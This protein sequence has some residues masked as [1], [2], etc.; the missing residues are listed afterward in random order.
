MT[1]GMEEP[2]A[3]EREGPN[4]EAEEERDGKIK[5]EGK[6]AG[7]TGSKEGENEEGGGA[8]AEV[9]EGRRSQ[10]TGG[11]QRAPSN[12][13]PY[14]REY[15]LPH[16]TTHHSF[17]S[18]SFSCARHYHTRTRVSVVSARHQIRLDARSYCT[19]CVQW[20]QIIISAHFSIRKYLC[21]F[22]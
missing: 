12:T 7:G 11:M 16:F 8:L 22:V 6:R 19:R 20:L 13:G 5:G 14:V 21:F 17:P 10:C 2:D 3:R 15:I 18:L 1:G 4:E 9:L